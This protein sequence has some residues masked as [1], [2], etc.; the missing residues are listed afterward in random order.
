MKLDHIGIAVKNIEERLLIWQ[1]LLGLKLQ[2]TQ[3]VPQHKV[4]VA[5]FDL[6]DVK[7]ELLEPIG[8]ESPVAK[9]IEKRGE[10]I[11]HLCFEVKNIEKVLSD[12]KKNG[13]KPIDKIP[14]N[15]AYAGKIAFIHPKGMGGVLIEL[16]EK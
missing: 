14:R 2:M 13:I 11:H 8:N 3:E 15:G 16:S 1:D 12:M 7:I 6:G 5:V 4:K 10:G 9:F